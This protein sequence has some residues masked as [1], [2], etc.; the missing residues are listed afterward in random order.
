[1]IVVYL[2]LDK[3]ADWYH[4]SAVGPAWVARREQK[5]PQWTSE[6]YGRD[7]IF[8]RRGGR[9]RSRC[10][11]QWSARRSRRRCEWM[12]EA[13]FCRAAS[14]RLQGANKRR[15]RQPC[16]RRQQ[17]GGIWKTLLPISLTMKLEEATRSD[18]AP[19]H[20]IIICLFIVPR[21]RVSTRDDTK[22]LPFS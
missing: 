16:G 6:N 18:G 15:D 17:Q 8:I 10:S 1:M 12:K 2:V 7:V 14:R 11:S 4:K 3:K 22:K 5:R 13:S 21:V 19:L 9:Q 20:A